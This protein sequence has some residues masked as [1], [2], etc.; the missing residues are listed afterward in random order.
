M[1]DT[2]TETFPDGTTQILPA[3]AN[4]PQASANDQ[5]VIAQGATDPGSSAQLPPASSQPVTFSTGRNIGGFTADVTI[6]EEHTDELTITEHPVE[7]GA[8][9]SDHAYKNPMRVVIRVGYS[10]SSDQAGGD[11]GYVQARYQDF[12]KLQQGRQPFAIITGKRQYSNMLIQS[13]AVTTDQTTENALL[14]TVTCREV[15]IVSTQTTTVP[16]ADQHANPQK[17]APLTNSGTVQPTA[18]KSANAPQSI[19]A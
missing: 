7:Q 4:D 18:P 12:L 6:A 15:I 1:A 2:I 3:S 10:N 9:I 5:S 11:T 16:P 13:L 8:S 19:L 17:T 14:L